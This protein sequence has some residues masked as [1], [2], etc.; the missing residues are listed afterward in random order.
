MLTV[1]FVQ[2]FACLHSSVLQLVNV[3][4]TSVCI[5]RMGDALPDVGVMVMFW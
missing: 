1:Q 5:L 4:V 3:S 2:Q